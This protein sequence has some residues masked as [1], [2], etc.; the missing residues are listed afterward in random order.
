[1]KTDFLSE[2]VAVFNPFALM[3]CGDLSQVDI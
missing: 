3:N 1:M 2:Y